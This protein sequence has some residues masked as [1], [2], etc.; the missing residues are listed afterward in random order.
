[1]AGKAGTD[2]VKE[3]TDSILTNIDDFVIGIGN[4]FTDV[5][6][7]FKSFFTGGSFMKGFL[8]RRH[9]DVDEMTSAIEQQQALVATLKKYQEQNPSGRMGNPE[10]IFPIIESILREKNNYLTGQNILIDGGWTS[11]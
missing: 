11:I 8:R 3:I 2:R 10:D 9:G 4:F 5:A 1:M 7:G 6:A